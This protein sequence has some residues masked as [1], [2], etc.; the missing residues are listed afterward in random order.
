MNDFR[1]LAHLEEQLG[2][3]RWR[4]LIDPVNTGKIKD[5]LDG[6]VAA[7]LPTTMTIG[8][9]TYDIL[10]FL[11]G[12]EK[13]VKGDIMITRA[14]EMGAHQGKEDR[15]RLL[16]HQD[17]IP[18][19][20]RGKVVFVFTDDRHPAYLGFVY[21]VYWIDVRWVKSWFW[22]G[23]DWDDNYRVLRRKSA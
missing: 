20:L 17:E 12:D 11:R 18:V 19:A 6:L 22:L 15:E 10:S 2:E 9:R 16:K 1:P 21:Y 4:V 13:M 3:T 23:R 7:R 8:G 14:K 5:I